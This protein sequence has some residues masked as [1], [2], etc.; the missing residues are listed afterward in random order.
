MFTVNFGSAYNQRQISIYCA[1]S[2]TIHFQNNFSK[3]IDRILFNKIKIQ[4]VKDTEVNRFSHLSR[5]GVTL[6]V[7]STLFPRWI[8]NLTN[9]ILKS[10]TYIEQAQIPIPRQV[11]R[12]SNAGIAP[13][14]RRSFA[15]LMRRAPDF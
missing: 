15:S 9:T 1:L 11:W 5:S 3:T 14:Q 4:P 13:V 10:R 8:T 2:F 6:G 12:G 7:M